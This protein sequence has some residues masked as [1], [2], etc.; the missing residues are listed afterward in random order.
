MSGNQEVT[1]ES[2]SLKEVIREQ[3]TEDEAPLSKTFT[4]KKILGGDILTTQAVRRQIWLFL[5]ITFFVIIYISNRYSCQQDL[6]TID[7]LQKELKDAKHKALSSSS[8]LTEKS[9]ES[10]VLEVLQSNKDSV[11]KI[12]TQPPFVIRIEE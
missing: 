11:L 2:P 1:E 6:I 12:P 10:R 9:R 5:L 8:Q 4:L 7:R 3:A